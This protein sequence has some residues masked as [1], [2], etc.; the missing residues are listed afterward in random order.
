MNKLGVGMT[1]LR[2]LPNCQHHPNLAYY[3]TTRYPPHRLPKKTRPHRH[4]RP[5]PPSLPPSQEGGIYQSRLSSIN[6][7]LS[8]ESQWSSCFYFPKI[9]LN[10]PLIRRSI[11]FNGDVVIGVGAVDEEAPGIATRGCE[12]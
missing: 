11:L 5:A 9:H 8:L 2:S 1:W 6:M 7:T 10:H 12:G 3:A 4:S